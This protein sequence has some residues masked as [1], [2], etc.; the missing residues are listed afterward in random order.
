[1]DVY[2]PTHLPSEARQSVQFKAEWLQAYITAF[3]RPRLVTRKREMTD[4]KMSEKQCA[5]VRAHSTATKI[6]EVGTGST[7]H[8]EDRGKV[9]GGIG[10]G[11]TTHLLNS[12]GG[13]SGRTILLAHQPDVWRPLGACNEEA[14]LSCLRP[15]AL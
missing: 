6:S 10:I 4:D 15:G 1:M 14:S 7:Y 9:L 5:M 8:L 11:I 13:A 2:S 12:P 3:A